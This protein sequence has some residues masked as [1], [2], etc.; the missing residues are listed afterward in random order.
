MIDTY[1]I[2]TFSGIDFRWIYAMNSMGCYHS[3]NSITKARKFLH[4]LED[5]GYFKL[6]T[7]CSSAEKRENYKYHIILQ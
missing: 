6:D 7:S 3:G 4:S 5:K 2:N 1:K